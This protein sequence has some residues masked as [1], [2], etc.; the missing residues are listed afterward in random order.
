MHAEEFGA[1]SPAECA[2][3]FDAWYRREQRL[4]YRAG[5]L[6]MLI[7]NANRDHKVRPFPFHPADFFRS[8]EEL[9]DGEEDDAAME[10]KIDALFESLGGTD[11]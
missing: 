11:A 4:D 6:A 8:L 3:I 9:R 5:I 7:A 1:L 10:S 2:E